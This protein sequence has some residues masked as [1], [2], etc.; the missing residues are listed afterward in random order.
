[1]LEASKIG[2]RRIGT[3]LDEQSIDAQ[4]PDARTA[5]ASLNVEIR[6][7]TAPRWIVPLTGSNR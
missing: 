6:A 3:L 7:A 4:P 2:D 1:V 5:V